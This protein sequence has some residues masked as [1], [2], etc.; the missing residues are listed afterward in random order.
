M[1]CTYVPLN[2]N[3]LIFVSNN[4]GRKNSREEKEIDITAVAE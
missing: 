2:Y 1:N 3:L 4:G